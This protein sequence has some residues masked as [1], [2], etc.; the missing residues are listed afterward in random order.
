M[1]QLSKGYQL[2]PNIILKD[3]KPIK[4][5][6]DPHRTFKMILK[7]EVLL[8]KCIFHTGDHK[9]FMCLI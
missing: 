9:F 6:V 8:N 4:L 5:V 7:S 2:V 1:K 3:I